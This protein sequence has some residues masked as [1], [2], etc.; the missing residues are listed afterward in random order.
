MR[1]YDLFENA[2]LLASPA[3]KRWFADSKV[4][5][6]SGK[7]LI[8]YHGTNQPVDRFS[9]S[10]RGLATRHPTAR[11][12][13]WFT[14]STEVAADYAQGAG[15][16]VRAGVD[17][18]EKK[19]AELKQ[20]ADALERVAQRSG[21]N[22]DWDKANAAMQAWEDLEIESLRDDPMTGQNVVPAYLRI[23]NPL[24]LDAEGRAFINIG[25]YHV[26][27]DAIDDAK[28]KKHD[29]LII[30]HL[31]DAMTVTAPATH[32]A[33]FNARQIKSAISG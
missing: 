5:N 23:V 12:A 2:K 28:R 26:L 3:F 32:Y 30:H 21:R 14:D 16:R 4:V 24:V 18:F 1:L 22:E 17:A 29:G 8:V 11:E 20:Q 7:P 33:V 27:S 31:V 15:E 13:F 9:A 6:S 25:E 19:S 10:R